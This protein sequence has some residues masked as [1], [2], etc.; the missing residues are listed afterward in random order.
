MSKSDLE[1]HREAAKKCFNE[2]WNYLEKKNRDAND[3]R[4]LLHLVHTSRYHWSIVGSVNALAVSDW[5]ISRAYAELNHPQLALHFA[6]SALEIMLKNNLTDLLCSGYEGIAR[7][8]AIAKEYQSAREFINKAREQLNIAS[9][10]DDE[11]KK[12]FSD[13]IQE[14]EQLIKR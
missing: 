8:Y 10:L 9:G 13:Q 14:T 12:I 4:T 3:E 5:Q 11:D 7:A 2:A 6:N 1:F